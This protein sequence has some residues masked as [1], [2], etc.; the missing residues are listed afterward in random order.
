LRTR[1]QH[2]TRPDHLS[3]ALGL[4]NGWTRDG[5][6]L[7]RTLSIDDSQHAAL[8]E[9]IK[10]AADT[11][12]LRPRIRRCDGLTQ[13]TLAAGDGSAITDDEV[14]LAARIEDAYRSV[15]GRR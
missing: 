6:L 3:D 4:L 9:R 10:V 12:H 8:T 5:G 15:T 7:G 14:A 2:K 11:W 13:I 1:R